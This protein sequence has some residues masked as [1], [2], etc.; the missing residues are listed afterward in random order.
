MTRSEQTRISIEN[1]YRNKSP[2]T[3]EAMDL[4]HLERIINLELVEEI[5]SQLVYASPDSTND[6]RVLSLDVIAAPRHRD[7]ACHD[8][9]YD[10]QQVKFHRSVLGAL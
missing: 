3:T 4:R 9:P 2:E 10:S 6:K 8:T 5:D 1:A 7:A